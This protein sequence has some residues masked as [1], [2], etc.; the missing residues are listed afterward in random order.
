MDEQDK[1]YEILIEEGRL[2]GK[3]DASPGGREQREHPRFRLDGTEMQIDIKLLVSVI[4]VSRSGV[5]FFTNLKMSVDQEFFLRLGSVFSIMGRVVACE[6]EE[7]DPTLM[8]YRYRVR[9]S[10]VGQ[11]MELPN[12][13]TI[14][15]R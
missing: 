10:F 13:L 6:V 11:E 8:E 5:S 3:V 15:D 2:T 1:R 14:I 7:T 12:L 4:E 9:C